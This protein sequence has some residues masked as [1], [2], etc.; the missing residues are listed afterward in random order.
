MRKPA[1]R[2]ILRLQRR[3]PGD[4][5]LDM[6][7]LRKRLGGQL[8]HLLEGRI[9]QPQPAVAREHR[10]RFGEIVERLALYAD[11]RVEAA[12]EVEPL[13]DI[14]EQIGHA[15]FGVRRGHHAQGAAIRQV[16]E[17]L[18]RF[19]IPIGL[20][21]LVLPGAE[22]LLLRQ[23]A[24]S[25]Q[26]VEDRGIGRAM[27]QVGHVEV[28]QR[29][30]GLVIESQRVV[31]AEGRNAGRELIERTTMRVDHAL[32]V[33]ADILDFRRIDADGSAACR[34]RHLDHV[35]HPPFAGD[36][37]GDAAAIG[38]AAFAHACGVVARGLVEQF[39]IALDRFGRIAGF[40]RAGIGGV[41]E[42]EPSL[43]VA[44]PDR[45]RAAR[46]SGCGAP[47]CRRPAVR[48]AP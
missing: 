9:V 3:A 40:D 45:E 47:S 7:T 15:A 48:G 36:H 4:D 16:P 12:L 43:A 30:I 25:A 26:A 14:V 18:P 5:G 21:Q 17:I 31:G 33:G 41:D 22:I 13:G 37:R 1:E 32:H 38:R 35:E 10:H 11:Q 39:E 8:P 28:P 42:I 29:A 19:D 46:R 27:I 23:F 6:R 2:L 44:R 34:G 20:V 24:P